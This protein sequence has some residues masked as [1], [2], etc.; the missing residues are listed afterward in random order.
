MA[1]DRID[2]RGRGGCRARAFAGG[3]RGARRRNLSRGF[4]S[5]PDGGYAREFAEAATR[6][7][8]GTR[9]GTAKTGESRRAENDGVFGRVRTSERPLRGER[10]GARATICREPE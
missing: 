1:C 6:F 9:L 7:A 10:W 3:V 2:A 4:R 8:P 5:I